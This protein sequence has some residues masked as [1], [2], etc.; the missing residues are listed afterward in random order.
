METI[1]VHL[2]SA[3]SRRTPSWGR[4]LWFL[5]LGGAFAF[6]AILLITA[7]VRNRQMVNPDAVSYIRASSYYLHGRLD[8]AVN[9]YWGPLL[10]WIIVPL[11]PLFRDPVGAA[12]VAMGLSAVLFLAGCVSVFWAF[13]LSRAAV[14]AGT[15]L[16]AIASVEWSVAYITP[17]L[18]LAGLL[19]LACSLVLAQSWLT[20]ARTQVGAGLL[21]GAAYLAKAIALPFALLFLAAMSAIQLI[22]RRSAARMVFSAGVRT[23]AGFAVIAAP[24]MIVLSLHYGRPVFSTSGLPAHAIVGP[25]DVE[26]YHPTFVAWR[27]PPEGRVTTWEEPSCM[28]YRSW[29]PLQN[30]TYARHQAYLILHNFYWVLVMLARFDSVGIGLT[31]LMAALLLHKRWRPNMRGHPWRWA[32]V[33]VACLVAWYLPV[34]FQGEARYCW[35]TY[36]FILTAA[37]GMA[38]WLAASVGGGKRLLGAAVLT[39]VILAF[40]FPAGKAT[41]LA[42]RGYRDA[43]YDCARDVCKRLD[44]AGLRGPIASVGREERVGFYLSFLRNEPFYGSHAD[45]STQDFK[46]VRAG[47]YVVDRHSVLRQR[48]E[49]QVALHD[50]DGRLF[51]SPA[52]AA[53]CPVAVYGPR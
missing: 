11:L 22:S 21:L 52:E 17:D 32:A 26:R 47:L 24:W 13:R 33:P 23:M 43:E 29:S 44:A 25:N 7:G 8:L 37:L 6:Q 15:W 45:P 38:E 1:E 36:V 53:A 3:S 10:S 12:R 16:A 9:G 39:V 48:L 46:S 28:P 4:R 20:R 40:G 30:F 42:L 19:A 14:L 50:L 51:S 2:A 31:S 5:A 18:L 41:A 34:Y 35:P 27:Q 49:A